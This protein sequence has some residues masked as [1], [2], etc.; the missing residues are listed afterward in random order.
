VAITLDRYG[1]LFEAQERKAAGLL[2]AYLFR[3]DTEARLAQVRPP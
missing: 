1:K 2:D 3:A